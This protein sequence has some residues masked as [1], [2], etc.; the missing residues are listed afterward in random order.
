LERDSIGWL[1]AWI[2]SDQGLGR[3]LD[4]DIGDR[5]AERLRLRPVNL[6]LSVG[7][8]IYRPIAT[9]SLPPDG[10]PRRIDG[11]GVC[12]LDSL[13]GFGPSKFLCRGAAA[14]SVRVAL[15]DG[16]VFGGA[17]TYR[18]LFQPSPV[19]EISTS[20]EPPISSAMQLTTE[21]PIAHIRRDLVMTNVQ[22][23]HIEARP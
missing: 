11:V 13:G 4:V 15:N 16:S 9:V 18:S 14:P 10:S 23:K 7:M 21:Q 12:S 8:T 22:L 19:F 17:F 3:W 6:R 2:R 20:I 5:L 1:W